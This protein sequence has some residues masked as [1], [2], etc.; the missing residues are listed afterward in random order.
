MVVL[1]AV[2]CFGVEWCR[3]VERRRGFL[4]LNLFFIV[5]LGILGSTWRLNLGTINPFGYLI[6]IIGEV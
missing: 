5:E 6:G 4:A 3:W 2:L 1:F